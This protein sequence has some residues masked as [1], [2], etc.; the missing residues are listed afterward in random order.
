MFIVPECAATFIGLKCMLSARR[1][2]INKCW[3]EIPV[4]LLTSLVC[5]ESK[6]QRDYL[7]GANRS[8]VKSKSHEVE[9][10]EPGSN[11]SGS[12]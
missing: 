10:Q 1:K 3:D 11:F 2:S 9:V 5:P 8:V 4:K 7:V 12:F 6:F